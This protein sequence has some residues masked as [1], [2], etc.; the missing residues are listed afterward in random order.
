VTAS[1]ASSA[2]ALLRDPHGVGRPGAW[3][4]VEAGQRRVKDLNAKRQHVALDSDGDG[5]ACEQR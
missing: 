4:K 1:P 2:D 3:D 5:I